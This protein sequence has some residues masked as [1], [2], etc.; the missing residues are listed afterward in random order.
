M[1]EAFEALLLVI[2]LISGNGMASEAGKGKLAR[3]PGESN[4]GLARQSG[5]RLYVSSRSSH[6]RA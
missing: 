4:S 6:L 2:V 5:R 1:V 3:D